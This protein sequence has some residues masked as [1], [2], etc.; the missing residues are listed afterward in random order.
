[1]GDHREKRD[2]LMDAANHLNALRLEMQQTIAALNP[3][4]AALVNAA[5]KHL[6]PAV[7]EA[8][9]E[10]VIHK[11]QRPKSIDAPPTPKPL[12]DAIA[13]AKSGRKRRAC[14]ICRQSG[15]WAKNCPDQRK[16]KK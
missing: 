1:M 3:Y 13:V 14:S 11:R 5:E 16:G 10:P 8:E 9:Y 2:A 15:H 12:N 7:E 6:V 4:I